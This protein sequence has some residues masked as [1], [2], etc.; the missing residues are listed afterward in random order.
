MVFIEKQFAD[1]EFKHKIAHREI[2]LLHQISDHANIVTMVDH[3]PVPSWT[4]LGRRS[5]V[6][7][8]FKR[9]RV[10]SSISSLA[11]LSPQLR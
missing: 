9:T 1:K 5:H 3:F 11:R 7:S 8:L 4:S 10:P 6:G 2:Q